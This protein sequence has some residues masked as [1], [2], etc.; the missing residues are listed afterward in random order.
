MLLKHCA[1]GMWGYFKTIF[2][3]H[4]SKLT[5]QE[6]AGLWDIVMPAKY[7]PFKGTPIRLVAN[8]DTPER[9]VLMQGVER[10]GIHFD[11]H[12]WADSDLALLGVDKAAVNNYFK[13]IGVFTD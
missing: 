9:F 12:V 8:N 1:A 10:L 5:V 3:K 4:I 7:R 6:S 11:G 13:Q 2:M